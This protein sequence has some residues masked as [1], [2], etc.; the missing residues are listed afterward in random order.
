VAPLSAAAA[1]LARLRGIGIRLA[2]A[3]LA[4]VLVGEW[5]GIPWDRWV[6]ILIFYGLFDAIWP[7]SVPPL[8]I[9]PNP[10]Q[11]R[12]VDADMAL[13]PTIVRE[14]DL[15]DLAEFTRRRYSACQRWAS[16][17]DGIV[18]LNVDLAATSSVN[19]TCSDSPRLQ[20]RSP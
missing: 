6:P 10:G 20:P 12:A 14:S 3:L 15:Q 1:A 19:S 8:D 7:V 11:K 13:L 16:R 17:N 4:T 5:A 9:P 2:V 18:K